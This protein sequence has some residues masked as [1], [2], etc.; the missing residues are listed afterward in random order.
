MNLQYFKN[1]KQF[2]VSELKQQYRDLSK[3]HHPDTTTGNDFEMAAINREYTFAMKWHEKQQK[4][5]QKRVELIN[6]ASE[7]ALE[8]IEVLQPKFEPEL[9]ELV[10]KKGKRLIHSK[11]PEPYR[12]IADMVL[13]KVIDDSDLLKI[14]RT[15]L[16]HLNHKI[17]KLASK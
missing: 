14:A 6:R 10:H 3:K 13:K 1:Y 15:G 12:E 11:V 8:G 7:K 5:K 9:K 4:K 2:S 16:E 17:N